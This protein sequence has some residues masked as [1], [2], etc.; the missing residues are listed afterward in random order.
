MFASG[1]GELKT[2]LPATRASAPAF[3]KRFPVS[4]LTPPSISIRVWELD[5]IINFF[6]L[7]TLL[8]VCSMKVC[9]PN[10]G[11]TLINKTTSI[12]SITSSN[13]ETGVCGF[14][15]T[16]GFHALCFYLLDSA[17]QVSTRFVMHGQ[18]VCSGFMKSL[19]VTFWLHNH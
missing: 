9:P 18:Y 1:S 12:S 8:I 14:S 10:P 5:S 2:K 7:S 13:R 3:T 16:P 19:H 4:K 17:V 15:E 6:S 11:L